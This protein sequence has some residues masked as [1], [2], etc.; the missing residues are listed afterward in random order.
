M[1]GPECRNRGGRSSDGRS[2]L[3]R[4]RETLR[5]YPW[6]G[7]AGRKIGGRLGPELP[8][9]QFTVGVKRTTA[10]DPV[11]LSKVRFDERT[12]RAFPERLSSHR[13]QRSFNGVSTST[14]MSK[15]AAQYLERM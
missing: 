7:K 6:S 14:L 2:L 9:Q 12:L 10:L 11:P 3:G 4:S 15:F 13:H 1:R 8:P 5:Q